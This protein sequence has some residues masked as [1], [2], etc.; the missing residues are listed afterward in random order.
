[1]KY[2]ELQVFQ[3]QEFLP[4][5]TNAAEA[6]IEGVEA[7]FAARPMRG[8]SLNGTVTYLDATF[9]RYEAPDPA[10][11]GQLFDLA[12]NRLTAT[13][14]WAVNLGAEYAAPVGEGELIVGLDYSY[15]SRVY[16]R[17]FNDL[18]SSQKAYGMWNGR[19]A[20]RPDGTGWE[21][22]VWVRNA[23]DELVAGKINVG[24]AI[25]GSPVETQYLPPRTYGITLGM[26][27]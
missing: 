18:A 6:T 25:L 26:R 16:F 24:G 4:L 8:L 1:M 10:R 11:G 13:P 15:K 19:I 17:P 21:A 22:S 27:F 23:T 14:E 2:E 9:D 5:I 3:I 7:E 12:G 20:Y